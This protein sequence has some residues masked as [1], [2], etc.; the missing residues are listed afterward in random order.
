MTCR[1]EAARQDWTA[2]WRRNSAR[3]FDAALEE[4]AHRVEENRGVWVT[5]C[6]NLGVPTFVSN[7][8]HVTEGSNAR[9]FLELTER[10]WS[11]QERL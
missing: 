8:L 10:I 4:T 2:T 5:T 3:A 11:T 7:G 1:E 9:G 6:R